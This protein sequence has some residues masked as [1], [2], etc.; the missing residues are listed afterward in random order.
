MLDIN[1]AVGQK[2]NVPSIAAERQLPQIK[3]PWQIFFVSAV[4]LEDG[5]PFTVLTEAYA[6]KRQPYLGG[7]QDRCGCVKYLESL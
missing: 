3:R 2:L 5:C 6:K 7:K 4:Q 1:V